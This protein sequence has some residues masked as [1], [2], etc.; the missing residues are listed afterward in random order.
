MSL[1]G[2]VAKGQRRRGPPP[3]PIENF[4]GFRV[5]DGS[6]IVAEGEAPTRPAAVAAARAILEDS[7]LSPWQDI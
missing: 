5:L 4:W 1:K 6:Q 3:Q 7:F 2:Q